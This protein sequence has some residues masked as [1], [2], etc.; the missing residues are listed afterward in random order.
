MPTTPKV[1]LDNFSDRL[2][3][4]PQAADLLS[5]S[6]G[7]L[8]NWRWKN[9]GPPFVRVGRRAVRYLIR[10]LHAFVNQNKTGKMLE[11][12]IES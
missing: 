3:T 6:T 11:S 5:V 9:Q 10:D 8:Q 2:L 12:S 1:S 7:T 4:T